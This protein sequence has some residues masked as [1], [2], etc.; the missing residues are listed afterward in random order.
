MSIRARIRVLKVDLLSSHW[1][2]VQNTT[3]EWQRTDG[4]WQAMQ[5]ETTDHGSAAAVLLYDLQRRTVVL[6]RQFRYATFVDGHDAL[7]LEVPA[8]LLDGQS[9]ADCVRSEAEQEVGIRV[10]DAQHAFSAYVCP[11]SLTECVHCF[12]AA[13][14]AADRIG[15]GGGLE[16]EGE[17]IE[18]LEFDFDDA[19]AAIADGRIRDAKTIMLLQ[20]AALRL[21]VPAAA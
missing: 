19:L 6:V 11:G 18:V 21:F 8:G 20:H 14:T 13:Y 10:R 5:R 16:E 3:L 12:T 17:D 15:A 4:R 9:P 2:T 7:M 1:S